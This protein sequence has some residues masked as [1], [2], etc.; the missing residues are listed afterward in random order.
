MNRNLARW[1][2]A[3]V[4]TATVVAAGGYFVYYLYQWQWVRAQTAG[5]FLIAALVVAGIRLL[6]TRVERLRGE[7]AQQVAGVA[8]AAPGRA[9]LVPRART[10]GDDVVEADFPW[11]DADMSPPRARTR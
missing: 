8:A 5:I 7:V 10:A 4:L 6:L 3:A 9:A 11:L 1:I 2:E